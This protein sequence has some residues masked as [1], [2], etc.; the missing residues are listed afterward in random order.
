MILPWSLSLS[1]N[2]VQISRAAPAST[3]VAARATCRLQHRQMTDELPRAILPGALQRE[4]AAG[5]A[6]HGER[7]QRSDVQFAVERADRVIGDDVDRPV[8]GNAA[9]G[10]PQARAS[11]CT[12]PKVSVRLGKTNT[13][14]AARARSAPRPSSRQGISRPGSAARAPPSAAPRRSTTLV[15]GRSSDRNASRFFSTATR[16]TVMKIGRG[17][18]SVAGLSG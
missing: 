15:P 4:A 8:T 13:S 16:P 5:F 3:G 9:T 6:R 12:T 7:A 1:L 14:A 18:S 10:V 11:S 17:K 2:D